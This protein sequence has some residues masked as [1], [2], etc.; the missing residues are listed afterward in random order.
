MKYLL[1]LVTAY[2]KIVKFD[3]INIE[4]ESKEMTD[5]EVKKAVYFE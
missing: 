5:L 4:I 3:L 1:I 2:L